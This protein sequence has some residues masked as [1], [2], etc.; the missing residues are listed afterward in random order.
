VNESDA[1]EYTCKALNHF[2]EATSKAQVTV[3]SRIV[4][5]L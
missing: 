5:I 4:F 2:G 3:T 1:G